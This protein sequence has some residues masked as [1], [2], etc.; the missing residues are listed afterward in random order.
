LTARAHDRAV[1]DLDPLHAEL[2]MVGVD[3]SVTPAL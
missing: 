1:A 2:L 3:L